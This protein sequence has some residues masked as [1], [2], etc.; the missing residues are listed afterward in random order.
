MVWTFVGRH[1]AGFWPVCE[2]PELRELE[3]HWFL[4]GRAPAE[5]SSCGVGGGAQDLTHGR[6]ARAL[7][8]PCPNH[9]MRLGVGRPGYAHFRTRTSLRACIVAAATPTVRDWARR[10]STTTGAY[11]QRVPLDRV[12]PAFFPSLPPDYPAAG[13]YTPLTTRGTRS[14]PPEAPAGSRHPARPRLADPAVPGLLAPS[15]ALLNY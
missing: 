10:R 1:F 15:R 6:D 12:E 11:A 8:Y 2:M 3:S 14:R 13:P 5:Q 4:A 9:R 7:P